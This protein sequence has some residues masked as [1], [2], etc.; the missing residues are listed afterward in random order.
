MF[1]RS[2]RLLL[3]R[4][5]GSYSLVRNVHV[6]HAFSP[7]FFRAESPRPRRKGGYADVGAPPPPRLPDFTVRADPV[8]LTMPTLDLSASIFC[9]LAGEDNRAE[10]LPRSTKPGDDRA[11][12][13][14]GG[15]RLPHREGVQV[16]QAVN[17][18]HSR[19]S[20]LFPAPPVFCRS[21]FC[22]SAFCRCCYS[23][24]W[25][26]FL[27]FAHHRLHIYDT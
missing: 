13:E 23:R 11:G 10:A 26:V 18:A 1:P 27:Y 12:R 5:P 24:V 6:Q 21:S 8:P 4:Q 15:E 7:P 14:R 19:R 9:V 22:A 20:H 16:S 2:A 3:A 17:Q 25:C